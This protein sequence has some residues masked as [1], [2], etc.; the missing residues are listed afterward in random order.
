MT[1]QQFAGDP[2]YRRHYWARYHVGWA[3]VDRARPNAGRRALV[4]LGARGVV[5][6]IITQNVDLLHEGAGAA[7]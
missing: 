4:S 3:H 6:A 2:A 1:F 7:T 5:V